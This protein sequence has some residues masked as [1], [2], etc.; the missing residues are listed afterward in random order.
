MKKV[1]LLLSFFIVSLFAKDGSILAKELGL[2][3]DTKVK[4]QWNRIF[5]KEKYLKR[6][7]IY[8]LSQKDKD[9][10]KSYLLKNSADA[11]SSEVA[12]D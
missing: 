8:E 7:G 9:K 12:G 6:Y 10:L 2:K 3:A 11:I 5:S 1:F 4:R